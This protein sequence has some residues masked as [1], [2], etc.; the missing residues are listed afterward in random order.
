MRK[1][2]LELKFRLS[3]DE[4]D[5]LQHKLTEAGMNRNSY[6]VRLITGATIFPRD[7]LIQLNL[8]HT[9]MNRLLRS[10]GVNINQIAKVANTN[11]A[12]PSA[13][14]LTDMHQDVQTLCHNLMPLWDKT[15]EALYGYPQNHIS[16]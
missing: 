12:T 7:Q 6:L 16:Q 8:E 3:P 4:F 2:P 13:A 11:H 5:L 10:I 15:R 14:L 9:M 1:R